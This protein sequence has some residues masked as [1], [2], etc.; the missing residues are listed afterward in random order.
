MTALIVILTVLAILL[1]L[2]IGVDA[3]FAN[4]VG[5]V[6]V[7]AGPA[8]F[9]ILSIP[10]EEKPADSEIEQ[11]KKEKKEKKKR[12]K[13]EAKRKKAEAKRKREET[14]QTEETAEKKSKKLSLE[15]ILALVKIA[16]Q[17]LGRLIRHLSIDLF[18]LHLVCGGSDP[19]STAMTYGYISA[20]LAAV[21]QLAERVF[22][23]RNRDLSVDVDFDAP[24]FGYAVRLVLTIQIWEIFAVV[25]AFLFAFI[26]L[27]IKL[28][29]EKRMNERKESDGKPNQRSDERID[30][31]DEGNGGR[32]HRRR[33]SDRVA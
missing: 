6:K 11:A 17:A 16:L 12:K 22:R 3:C 1:L 5:W 24:S 31:E 15:Q 10:K 27:Q 32:Q 14:E 4:G 9:K 28:R 33:R 13:A 29:R 20:G 21:T 25:F 26:K 7:K 8:R 19:Y 23:I 18:S 30:V 2:P